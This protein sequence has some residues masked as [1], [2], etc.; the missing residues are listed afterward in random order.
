MGID[1]EEVDL[2]E[3]TSKALKQWHKNAVKKKNDAG[4]GSSPPK[5][6][7]RSPGDS[8]VQSP[9]HARPRNQSSEVVEAAD[10]SSSPRQTANAMAMSVDLQGNNIHEYLPRLCG[11]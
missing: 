8:P 11:P 6:F 7:S 9:R 1:D 5:T 2:D 4:R 3:Q 10:R